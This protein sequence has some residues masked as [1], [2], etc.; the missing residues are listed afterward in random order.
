MKNQE[1]LTD[2]LSTSRNSRNL[3][4]PPSKFHGQ[5]YR[6]G[7]VKPAVKREGTVSQVGWIQTRSTSEN[8]LDEKK[9]KGGNRMWESKFTNFVM[10]EYDGWEVSVSGL[11]SNG[12]MSARIVTSLMI[13]PFLF[14]VTWSK[15]YFQVGKIVLLKDPFMLKFSCC[16]SCGHS[17]KYGTGSLRFNFVDWLGTGAF[18]VT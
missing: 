14:F 10:L 13:N 15:T 17:S 2:F 11:N 1:K 9:Y 8:G 16:Y 18:R 4:N 3:W 12:Q 7:A 5:C 6:A